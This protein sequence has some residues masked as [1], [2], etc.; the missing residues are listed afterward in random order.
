MIAGALS[1][2]LGG[3]RRRRTPSRARRRSASRSCARC[4][5]RRSSSSPCA[6]CRARARPGARRS[7]SAVVMACMNAC[8]YEAIDR[9]PLGAAVT[10]EFW[11]PIAVAVAT[12]RRRTDLIWVALA[13]AGVALLGEG[14]AERGARRPRVHRR[15]RRPV[16]ALHRARPPSRARDRPGLLGLV[17]ACAISAAVLAAPGI[18]SARA[19]PARAAGARACAPCSGC[20]G[21]RS[22]TRSRCTPCAVCPR[23]RSA[24]CSRCTPPWP[25]SSGRRCSSQGLPLRDVVAIACVVAASAGALAAAARAPAAQ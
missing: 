21:R 24:S 22:R 12:S 19:T 17:P 25:R 18:A 10:I 7:R 5:R 3:A 4:S 8:F 14:F 2:Q 15:G 11:G 9:L 20:W 16:G 13:V 23:A 1:V 6:R